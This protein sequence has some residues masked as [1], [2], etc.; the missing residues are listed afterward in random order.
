MDDTHTSLP[1]I[2]PEKLTMLKIKHGELG[3][4]VFSEPSS[5]TSGHR[6]L[7]FSN[8]MRSSV[9]R[10]S[11]SRSASASRRRS[12]FLHSHRSEMSRELTSQAEGKF[13][14]LMDLMSTAS[15]EASS[16]KESWARIVSE[17]EALLRERD[18]L[19]A[20][21]EEVT[22]TLERR[23]SEYHHHGH[24]SAEKKKYIEK[25]LLELSVAVAA[26][27][28]HKNKVADKD[29]ELERTRTELRELRSSMTHTHS[30]HEAVKAE[31]EATYIKLRA[32]EDDRDHARDD[33]HKHHGE[34]RT[35]L[36]EHT[37]LKS[38]F[39]EI[40][41]K[42]ESSR[43]EVLTLNDR[44]KIWELERDE[45]LHEKDRLQ[46]ELRRAKHRAEESSRELKELTERHERT[47]HDTT[48]IKETLRV[49]E[50]E[51][52][53]YSLSVENLRRDVKAKA[54][55]WEEADGRCADITLKYEHLKREVISVK[56]KLRDVEVRETELREA[57]ER[58]R[59]QHRLIS[60][61]RDQ[62]KEDLHDE[63]GKV[64]DGHRRIS[65]LEDSLRRVESTVT[66]LRSEIHTL[67]ERNKTLLR[68][69]EEG[70]FQHEHLHTEL[71]GL[72]EKMLILQA[73]LRIVSE[74]R[75][76]YRKELDD[77]KHKYEEVT[78]T[79][80]EYRD[81]SG[82][83][84]FEI[85]SL[86]TLLREAREQKERAISARHTADRERDEYIAKYEEKCREMEKF[87]ES[88]SA[89]Y[90]S[91]SKGEGKSSFTRTVSSGT[92]V[93]HDKHSHHNIA[94]AN[95]NGTFSP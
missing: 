90:H 2:A 39:T 52:D 34:L 61:E 18:E 23:E 56:E 72:K 14:A 75:D 58:S 42:F 71:S 48:K 94:E 25:L 20:R 29:R 8:D 32:C 73:E 87:E 51:R 92:T 81:D 85:E 76:H 86:R 69:E 49:V 15:R 3:R 50:I 40:S 35:L 88:A 1:N 45:H 6:S 89:H 64:A 43:K 70:R 78:E 60:I 11:T 22:E 24:E 9:T 54:A 27:Q 79:I 83:L 82:E 7:N 66:E 4:A 41:S 65:V 47:L 37:D 53:E 21:V 57:S 67:T 62:L 26:V 77:W 10:R 16:L 28:E 30:E 31:L 91:H 33:S 44:V 59:E 36:R 80:T 93:H 55:G 17:R 74:T 84:E 68:E 19:L 46:E 12:S 95:G 38:K 63:C 13:F 5:P